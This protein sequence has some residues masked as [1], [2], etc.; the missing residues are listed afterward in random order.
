VHGSAEKS[1]RI[2]IEVFVLTFI[3]V[4]GLVFFNPTLGPVLTA[5]TV[6]VLLV[7]D[8]L[9]LFA[10]LGVLTR[11]K[12][13]VRDWRFAGRLRRDPV[14]VPDLRRLAQETKRVFYEN[15]EGTML[16]VTRMFTEPDA[17]LRDEILERG[18]LFRHL[19]YLSETRA[20]WERVRLVTVVR[21]IVEHFGVADSVLERL[22]RIVSRAEVDEPAV[23]QWETFR[24][25]YNQLRDAWKRYSE[26]M[27]AVTGLSATIP[28][29]PARSLNPS[30]VRGKVKSS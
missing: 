18:R 4:A 29:Q 15:A 1:G 24:E 10:L 13:R 30:R 3:A 27:F 26:R 7:F 23:A 14:L 6:A 2:G 9:F 5:I 16:Y 25:R 19:L 8:L 12:E 11:L 21:A 20:R 22:Y 17:S 28:G